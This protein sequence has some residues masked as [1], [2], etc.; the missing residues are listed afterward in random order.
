[1]IEERINKVRYD[2]G[3][4]MGSYAPDYFRRRSAANGWMIGAGSVLAVMGIGYLALRLADRRL[5]D[6]IGR[7]VPAI[8]ENGQK[9]WPVT[10][11]RSAS[12]PQGRAETST[13]GEEKADRSPSERPSVHGTEG[14]EMPKPQPW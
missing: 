11:G 12:T 6:V 13:D 5:Q 2:L 7:L 8:R 3:D 9:R 1:M 14:G 4:V 10:R